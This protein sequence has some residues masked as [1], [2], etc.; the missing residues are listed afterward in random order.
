MVDAIIKVGI[1]GQGRSGYNIHAVALARM[2]DRFRIVAVSDQDAGN[3]ERAEQQFGCASYADY[4]EML[5]RTDLDLI[6]N[7]SPSH[8]HVPLSIECMEAGFNVLCEKPLARTKE[9]VDL[10]IDTAERTGVK[11]TTFQQSRFAPAFQEMMRVIRSGIMGRV[12][13]ARIVFNGFHRRWDWQTLQSN[14]GGNLLNTGAHSLDQALQI[15]GPETMPDVICHMD[16]VNTFGDAEDYVKLILKKPGHP[17]IDM[18]ISSCDAYPENVYHIQ[19]EYGTIAGSHNK[20]TYKYFDPA[21]A[22][23]QHLI[24]E[25]LK[26]PDGNPAYCSETLPWEEATWELD[27]AIQTFNHNIEKFYGQLYRA[28][29]EN[30]PMEVT[31]EHVRVQIAVIEQCHLQNPLSRLDD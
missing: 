12:V 30:A 28:L 2:D 16:R 6:V 27:P 29:T 22:P 23:E 21:K 31:A 25:P 19:C 17:L 11:L 3:R 13:Q 20:L 9:E 10:L 8:L 7:A 15:F 26:G 24:R 5:Q 4:K 1:I 14:N 18:E